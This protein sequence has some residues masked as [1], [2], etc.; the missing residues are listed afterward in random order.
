M[1]DN[2]KKGLVTYL[3]ADAGVSAEVGTRIFPSHAPTSATFP[4]ITIERIASP[5]IHHMGAASGIVKDLFQFDVWSGKS[6]EVFATTEALRK[7][8][9]GFQRSTMGAV[10]VSSVFVE[11]QR[12]NF[13]R[14]DNGSEDGTY[15]TSFD[16]NIWYI[17]TVPTF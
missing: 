13:N 10:K 5:S 15:L 4:Y 7:A 9:D 1:P 16:F 3:K 17:R 11:N 12:D 8:L 2:I 14:P 6:K